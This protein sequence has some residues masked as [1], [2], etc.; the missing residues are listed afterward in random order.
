MTIKWNRE[1][2][3]VIIMSFMILIGAFYYGNLYFIKPIKEE[4]EFLTSTVNTQKTLLE[5][6]PPT[7]ERLAEY[8][9]TYSETESYLPLGDQANQ[10]LI[11]LEERAAQS[12]VAIQTVTREGARQTM[13]EIP[14]NFVKNTY[15]VEMTA[16]SPSHF[17]SLIKHLM[18]E[19]RVWNIPAFVYNKTGEDAYSGTITYEIFYL[20]DSNEPAEDPLD[21]IETESLEQESAEE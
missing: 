13:E 6:Y 15:N 18:E 8:E 5:E 19:E 12:N 1:T 16:N 7:E 21:E 11:I 10:A 9:A 14:S 17:R 20:S 3:L 4:T 2:F